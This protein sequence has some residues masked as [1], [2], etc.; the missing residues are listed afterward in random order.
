MKHKPSLKSIL[1]LTQEELAT[2]L[3]VTR[4]QLSMYEA[5]KRDL[6]LQAMIK[7]TNMLL[8]MENAKRDSEFLENYTENEKQ[9]TQ[10]QL[11]K[12]LQE[13]TYLEQLL[14]KRIKVMEKLRQ[15]SINALQLLDYLETKEHDKNNMLYQH[16]KNKA[17]IQLEKNSKIK[18]ERL[19]IKKTIL[20][21]QTKILEQKIK[22]IN[23]DKPNGLV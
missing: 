21:Q 8:Y 2:L 13:T 18:L 23:N 19:F 16:I 6:P 9:L 1:G 20:Q 3:G 22:T 15:E 17:L 4:A 7:L 10:K 5:S 11:E 14:E 12:K